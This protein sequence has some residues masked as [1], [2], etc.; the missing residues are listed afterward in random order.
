MY[1]VNR[2][3]TLRLFLSMNAWVKCPSLLTPPFPYWKCSTHPSLTRG[4]GPDS[5]RLRLLSTLSLLL[6]Q[7]T[8]KDSYFRSGVLSYLW[9]TN[10]YSTNKKVSLTQ[11]EPSLLGF[12]KN[13]RGFFGPL[14]FHSSSV[15]NDWGLDQ[16]PSTKFLSYTLRFMD[17]LFR[18]QDLRSCD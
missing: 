3:Y 7:T 12:Q 2:N 15:V 11:E 5:L 4:R 1:L 6:L 13:P 18:S 14:F 17:V 8:G 10:Q 16:R 9:Q